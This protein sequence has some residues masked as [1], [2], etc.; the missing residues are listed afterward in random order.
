[1]EVGLVVDSWRVLAILGKDDE[2][3]IKCQIIKWSVHYLQVYIN[4]PQPVL[5][6]Q[7]SPLH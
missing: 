5:T 1:M 7:V 4:L 2:F 6:S 3:Q